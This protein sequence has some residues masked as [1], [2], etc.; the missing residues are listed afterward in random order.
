VTK[1]DVEISGEAQLKFNDSLRHEI[2]GYVLEILRL[3]AHVAV[4]QSRLPPPAPPEPLVVDR[5]ILDA[6]Q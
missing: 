3:R 6:P 5:A 2:G 1:T 4:L